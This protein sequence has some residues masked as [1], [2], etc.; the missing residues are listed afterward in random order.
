MKKVRGLRIEDWELRIELA[1]A[2]LDFKQ[3]TSRQWSAVEC[4]QRDIKVITKYRKYLGNIEVYAWT[5]R[6]VTLQRK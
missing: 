1:G 6:L 5:M 3:R 4:S 2:F